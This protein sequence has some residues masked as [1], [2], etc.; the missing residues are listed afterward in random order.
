MEME[1]RTFCTFLPALKILTVILQRPK[2]C[3]LLFSDRDRGG[4]NARMRNQD[5]SKIFQTSR[6]YFIHQE[7][8]LFQTPHIGSDVNG[9]TLQFG[10]LKSL[11]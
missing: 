1:K 11:G 6:F 5:I 3:E 10:H 7:F 8:I 4:C 2:W 9:T